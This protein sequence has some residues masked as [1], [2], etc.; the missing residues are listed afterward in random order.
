MRGR[1]GGVSLLDHP[2]QVDYWLVSES[3]VAVGQT[4]GGHTAHSSFRE[5]SSLSEVTGVHVFVVNTQIA[6][7]LAIVETSLGLSSRHAIEVVI[8]EL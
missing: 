3:H 6:K 4:I 7:R 2:D 8:Y 1:S 5:L